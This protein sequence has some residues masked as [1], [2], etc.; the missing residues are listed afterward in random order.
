MRTQTVDVS[1][2]IVFQDDAPA[3]V[4]DTATVQEGGTGTTNFL[5]T[6][7][8]SFSMNLPSGVL[9]FATKLDLEKA[10]LVNLLNS[11]N[12][13]QVFIDNFATAAHD[14]GGWLSKSAAITFINGLTA[15][16]STNFDAALAD[17]E[18]AFT[19]AHTPADQT[20]A[21]FLSD[22][23]PNQP[24]GS[25]GINAAEQATWENFLTTNGI[26]GAV[27]VG[28]SS[29]ATIASL[30]PIA[31]PNGNP[32]NPLILTDPSQLS[33]T[34]INSL[35]GDVSGNVL[36]NDS[37]G[38]DG[39]GPGSGIVSILVDGHLYA[40]D[41]GTNAITQDGNPFA[42]GTSTLDLNTTLGGHFDF[43]FTS[44]GGFNAG[45]YDYKSPPNVNTDTV[46]SFH[47]V[48]ADGDGDTSGADLN[49]TVNVNDPP[50]AH[51]D[52]VITNIAGSG[53]AIAIPDLALLLNDTDSDGPFLSI[54][55]VGAAG[56][57]AVGHAGTTT[58]FTDN[59]PADGSFDYIVE[60]NGTPNLT[61]TAH[62]TIDRAQ[63]GN[64]ELDGTGANE[65][66]I[67]TTS[68][69]TLVGNGGSDILVGNGGA[70]HFLYNA[71]TDGGTIANQAG[72][73]H[74]L[75]FSTALGDS[76]DVKASAFGGGLVAGNDASGIFGS[77]AN[78][79]FGS[80]A[81]RF[82]FNTSTHTLLYDSNG[83]DAGGTQVALAVLE[84]AA[85]VDATHIHAVA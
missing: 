82:H 9:G 42:S 67:G 27:A 60:D 61:A 72:A 77:S 75:D 8:T 18:H 43:H 51:D 14:S 26:L 55:S 80:S 73:D 5:I 2:N 11:T 41:P 83:S 35:P 64:S 58:T 79:T 57:D 65:I 37:F 54:M 29:D 4:V 50:V 78:D 52:T 30:D 56:S 74:I 45:D 16:G 10:A 3:P 20:L 17:A 12:V 36:A 6:M 71:T 48:I 15:G 39:P 69:D 23:A 28:I 84:H 85:T 31:F 81:E 76:I 7:D 34:L 63:A 44:G 25:V 53:A 1:G 24:F 38:A 21:Y 68:A 62:V 66:L 32:N 19:F 59:N 46:E 22:G 40:Y 70:D 13:N 33:A 47:Y 49:I